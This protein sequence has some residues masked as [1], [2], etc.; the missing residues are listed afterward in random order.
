MS[1]SLVRVKAKITQPSTPSWDQL[2]VK[3][4]K[5]LTCRRRP[6]TLS[7]T[8]SSPTSSSYTPSKIPTPKNA[9]H[10]WVRRLPTVKCRYL[11]LRLAGAR[12]STQQGM[13]MWHLHLIDGSSTGLSCAWHYVSYMWSWYLLELTKKMRYS[14]NKL[15][16]GTTVPHYSSMCRSI[17][18]LS[19]VSSY[20][21]DTLA[22][23]AL[24]T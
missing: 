4:M 7:P 13:S 18:F 20:V 9:S 12:P 23:S 6:V 10:R 22:R 11:S 24:G 14:S 21:I 15:A 2:P 16:A 8:G 17:A 1:T 3:P 19:M 5:K